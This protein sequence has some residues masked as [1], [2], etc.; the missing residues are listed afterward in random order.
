[1]MPTLKSLLNSVQS[2]YLHPRN[3]HS[4]NINECR[5]AQ[6]TANHLFRCFTRATKNL[7]RRFHAPLSPRLSL[8]RHLVHRRLAQKLALQILLNHRNLLKVV[9][10]GLERHQRVDHGG[11][12]EPLRHVDQLDRLANRRR[13]HRPVVQRPRVVKVKVQ[14]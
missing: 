10:K 4:Q 3:A 2:I 1:M 9:P 7:A 5:P 11:R 12:L 13:R 14:R 8:E 6:S